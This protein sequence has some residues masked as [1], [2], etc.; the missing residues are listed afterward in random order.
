MKKILCIIFTFLSIS[1]IYPQ[2]Y[3]LNINFKDGTTVSYEIEDI[4]KIDFSDLTS[5]EDM[6][7][8]QAIVK[9]FKLRQNY[10]NPFNPSTTIRYEIPEKGKVEVSIFDLN[11]KLIK[12]LVN[13]YQTAGSHQIVWKG[14][15]QAGQKVASGF[16]IYSVKFNNTVSSKKMLLIK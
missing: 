11:G 9:S 13:R 5:L 3:F 15:N 10:P 2:T 14:E 7:K 16:Y 8:M 12:N 6:K 4:Q 1:Y